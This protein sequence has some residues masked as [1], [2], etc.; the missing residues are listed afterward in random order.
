LFSIKLK[1]S[2]AKLPG[3][4][5]TRVLGPSDR[6][7][8]APDE[9]VDDLI[10]RVDFGSDGPDPIWR[11]G[12]R[13]LTPAAD[14][15]VARGERLAGA[16]GSSATG[17]LAADCLVEKMVRATRNPKDCT[18]RRFWARPRLAVARCGPGHSAAVVEFRWP[19]HWHLGW[20]IVY[21]CGRKKGKEVRRG[22]TEAWSGRGRDADELAARL[23]GGAGRSLRSG[24]REWS[25]GR[26]KGR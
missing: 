25:R 11:A 6:D 13:R 12:R 1:G 16:G 3:R 26:E 20:Y 15:A 10:L 19:V 14:S 17:G 24:V 7:Q 2:L 21:P 5:G 22:L 18:G 23:G 4:T 9:G 8:R